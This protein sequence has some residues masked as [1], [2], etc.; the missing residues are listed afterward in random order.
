MSLFT[1]SETRVQSKRML[2]EG[3]CVDTHFVDLVFVVEAKV[4]GEWRTFCRGKDPVTFHNF[5]N[6]EGYRRLMAHRFGLERA[7]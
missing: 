3:E 7:A 4:D 6:A 5:S 1:V 2:C